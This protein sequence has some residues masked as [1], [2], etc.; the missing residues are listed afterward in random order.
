[1]SP[2]DEMAEFLDGY[3]DACADVGVEPLPIAALA[4]LAEMLVAVTGPT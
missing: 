4:E 3:A 1:M 2:E